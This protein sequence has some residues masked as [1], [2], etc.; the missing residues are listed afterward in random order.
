MPALHQRPIES[1][2][3]HIIIDI[4]MICTSVNS[5]VI[6]TVVRGWDNAVVVLFM[7]REMDL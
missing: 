1:F 7:T 6:K 3:V 2:Q 4:S 5:Y